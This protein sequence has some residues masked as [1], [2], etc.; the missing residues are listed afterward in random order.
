MTWHYHGTMICGHGLAWDQKDLVDQE[1]LDAAVGNGMPL[2]CP[3][4][5]RDVVTVSM[6]LIRE[7]GGKCAQCHP[8]TPQQR[9][10]LF[11]LLIDDQ[12]PV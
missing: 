5:E 6:T 4:C 2:P 1:G 12:P 8:M 11:G 3:S 10:T 7:G 9:R